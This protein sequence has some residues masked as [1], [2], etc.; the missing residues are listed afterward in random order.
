LEAG[1]VGFEDA[2]FTIVG[3]PSG[4]EEDNLP[5]QPDT[6]ELRF[7]A[8][9]PVLAVFQRDAVDPVDALPN[10]GYGWGGSAILHGF[11]RIRIHFHSRD[12]CRNRNRS[13][14][15]DIS[16]YDYDNDYDDEQKESRIA[17]E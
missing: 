17:P 10:G 14:T 7:G 2:L 16:D 4:Q 12:R 1:L 8:G 5:V 13:R 11:S 3:V 9:L 6:T 15:Q